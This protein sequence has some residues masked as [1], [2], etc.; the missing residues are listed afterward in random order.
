MVF[1]R[2]ELERRF[3]TSQHRSDPNLQ[4]RFHCWVSFGASSHTYIHDR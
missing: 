1:F 3:I 4:Y 2:E